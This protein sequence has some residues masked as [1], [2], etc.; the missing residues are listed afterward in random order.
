MLNL[1]LISTKVQRVSCDNG[2]W[3]MRVI[4]PRIRQHIWSL[5]RVTTFPDPQ[6]FSITPQSS[7][8][9]PEIYL[10]SPRNKSIKHMADGIPSLS[11]LVLWLVQTV[12]NSAQTK[13]HTFTWRLRT[14]CRRAEAGRP[15]PLN[16]DLYSRDSHMAP[17]ITSVRTSSKE[18]L[19]L[20]HK[21]NSR[22][23]NKTFSI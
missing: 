20:T 10:L 16:R 13:T 23:F 21:V 12:R 15:D 7:T 18:H 14:I 2:L 4:D 1:W 9:S 5:Y 19:T 17:T 6:S 11:I 3:P 8:W 22:K